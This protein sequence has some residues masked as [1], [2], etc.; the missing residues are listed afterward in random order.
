MRLFFSLGLTGTQNLGKIHTVFKSNFI[1]RS[2]I[3][4]SVKFIAIEFRPTAL[5]IQAFQDSYA[6]THF[7]LTSPTIQKTKNMFA[8][9]LLFS[10]NKRPLS[11][12]LPRKRMKGLSVICGVFREA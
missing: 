9:H 3:L 5:M 4:F 10:G 2:N 11:E 8:A 6:I 12:L 7:Y 1:T